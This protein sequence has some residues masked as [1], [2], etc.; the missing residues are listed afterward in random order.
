[1]LERIPNCNCWIAARLRDENEAGHHSAPDHLKIVY[2]PLLLLS[3][4]GWKQEM[5]S[6]A[7]NKP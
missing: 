7:A 3:N 4:H 5:G 1:M 2:L 6:E